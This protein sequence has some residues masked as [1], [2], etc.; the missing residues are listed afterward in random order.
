MLSGMACYV[1]AHQVIVLTRQRS[2]WFSCDRAASSCRD[3]TLAG[4]GYADTL[5]LVSL[6]HGGGGV[7]KDPRTR[8]FSCDAVTRLVRCLEC[9]EKM[10][11]RSAEL[12]LP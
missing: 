7:A 11:A 10:A 5:K 4:P 1:M 9:G 3:S 2:S 8:G 6:S 12:V